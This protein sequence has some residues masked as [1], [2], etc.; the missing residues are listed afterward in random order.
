MQHDVLTSAQ[1]SELTGLRITTIQRWARGGRLSTQPAQMRPGCKRVWTRADVD[2]LAALKRSY[3]LQRERENQAR[4]AR[5]RPRAAWSGRLPV[6][7]FRDF[8]NTKV[9]LVPN[10]KHWDDQSRE[11]VHRA[12]LKLRLSFDTPADLWEVVRAYHRLRRVGIPID[13]ADDLVIAFGGHPCDVWP[14]YLERSLQWANQVEARRASEQ[15]E[16]A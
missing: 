2:E 12:W 10:G 6:G 15:M 7:P 4:Q 5:R 3:Q 9:R 16:V 13:L 8:L 1:V 11:N 14:D